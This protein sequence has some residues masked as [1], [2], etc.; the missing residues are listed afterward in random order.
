M[1]QRCEFLP[2][3]EYD[4]ESFLAVAAKEGWRVPA[5]E[6]ELFRGPFASGAL[7]LHCGGSFAGMVTFVNYGAT[8][9]IGNL[10]V[11]P[12]LRGQGLGRALFERA[13][14]ELQ[15]RG[16]ASVWLTASETGF[17]LY[18]AQGFRTIG[19]VERWV[20]QTRPGVRGTDPAGNAECPCA[21]ELERIFRQADAGVWG[22]QRILLDHLLIGGRLFSCGQQRALLQQEPG[23]GILGPWY[24][25]GRPGDEQCKLLNSIRDAAKCCEELVADVLG[26]RIASGLMEKAGFVCSGTTRLMVLG[27]TAS[28]NLQS[29]VA[30]AS[31]GSVG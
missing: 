23:R 17:P 26:G 13:L 24:G 25:A 2:P 11:Q 6:I 9:W 5:A 28:I 18:A 19:P 12:S 21:G 15:K 10:I 16:A 8:A 20:L 22:G 29:L 4:W 27:D 3:K 14:C 30:L 31:L 7:A 1:N